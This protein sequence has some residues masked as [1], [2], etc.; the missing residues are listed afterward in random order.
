MN[1][2]QLQASARKRP[3]RV[4]VDNVNV[5]WTQLRGPTGVTAVAQE[6]AAE[7]VAAITAI[8]RVRRRLSVSGPGLRR[9]GDSDPGARDHGSLVSGH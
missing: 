1:V 4:D 7:G 8:V 2:P 9:T 6:D 3:T 5:T